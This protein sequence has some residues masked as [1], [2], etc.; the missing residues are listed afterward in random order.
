MA[1]R[2]NPDVRAL[3][4]QWMKDDANRRMRESFAKALA[5]QQARMV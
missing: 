4:A 5:T 1:N 2:T 3:M